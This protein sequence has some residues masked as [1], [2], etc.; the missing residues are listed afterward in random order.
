MSFFNGITLST[1]DLDPDLG[2]LPRGLDVFTIT[3]VSSVCIVSSLLESVDMIVVFLSLS[4]SESVTSKVCSSP[5][6]WNIS[7]TSFGSFSARMLSMLISGDRSASSSFMWN[8]VLSFCV[9]F[10][11][12]WNWFYWCIFNSDGGLFQHK[13][14]W[15]Y[16]DHVASMLEQDLLAILT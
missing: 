13:S 8:L 6:S 2:G 9:V 10:F 1:V 7:S 16:S 3:G 5:G 14:A 11:S 15:V 12:G 4:V